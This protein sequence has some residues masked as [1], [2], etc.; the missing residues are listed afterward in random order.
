MYYLLPF[1]FERLKG[2]E[3][4]VNEAGDY[5][6]VPQHTVERIVN[7]EITEAEEIY[8]DLIASF[9]ISETPLPDLI[10]NYAARLRTKKAFLDLFTTL[11]IFVLTLRCNQNCIYCQASSKECDSEIFDMKE[12]ALLKAIDLMF[13]SPSPAITMEFQGGEPSLVPQLLKFAIEMSEQRNKIFQKEI[14]YV[15]CSN[16]IHFT[17][18]LLSICSEYNVLIST[19]LDGPEF[20]HNK[21]RGK[22]NSYSQ[23]IAGINQARQHL[24]NDRVS[25]L[26]TTSD[27]SLQFPHEIIDSYIQ[28]GFNSIF[29]RPL[30]PYGLATDNDWNSY[31][32]YFV[33]FYK[34][35]LDYIIEIN[36]SGKIFVEEFTALILRK[37]LTPF[38]CGFVD[39]Q[40]PAGIIN[41]VIVYNYDGY[42]YASDESRMLAEYQDY[43]FRLGHVTD[44]YTDIFY[45]EK[46]QQ[47]AQTWATEVIAGCSDCAFQTYCGADPVRNYSTQKDVYGHRPSSFLC[48]KHKAI[49]KHIFSLLIEREK[50]VMPI[51][52]TWIKDCH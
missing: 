18:E 48:K 28:N 21:N 11:H 50:E 20:L 42:V 5:L 12:S 25:A 30:N 8:K 37:I 6:I 35:A 19:S 13:Q 43:T 16:S 7:K 10:D 45:G 41:N 27:Y 9:F 47:L 29:L 24:G 22:I 32:Q 23:V 46:A 49:I 52:K 26:M 36:K 38:C 17:E 33:E 34:T 14:T 51:F 44:K 15:L 2:N 4:L 31:Y 40:S 3:I 1:R 39:L